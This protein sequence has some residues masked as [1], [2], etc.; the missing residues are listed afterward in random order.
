MQH[1]ITAEAPPSAL[2][3]ANR[4]RFG[5]EGS[6]ERPLGP[7][8]IFARSH[9]NQDVSEDAGWAGELDQDGGPRELRG[10]WSKVALPLMIAFSSTGFFRM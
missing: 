1:A 7:I 9:R 2:S 8:V 10:P 3:F 6:R 4:V 5:G